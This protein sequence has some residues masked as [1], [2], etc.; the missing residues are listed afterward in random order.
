MPIEMR[1]LVGLD[2]DTATIWS[3]VAGHLR[4]TAS[5]LASRQRTLLLGM[6]AR[7]ALNQSEASEL[8]PDDGI[9]R[10]LEGEELDGP[11]QFVVKSIRSHDGAFAGRLSLIRSSDALRRSGPVDVLDAW[12][13][14]IDAN[15]PRLLRTATSPT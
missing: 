4:R 11:L 15:G 13:L 1:D 9:I 5:S 2:P 12:E 8:P 14:H 3:L 10:L 6:I 7:A